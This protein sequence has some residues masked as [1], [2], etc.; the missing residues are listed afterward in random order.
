M[1]G[2]PELY[3]TPR[4]P[5]YIGGYNWRATCFGLP[6]MPGWNYMERLYRPR[7]EILSG[8]WTFPDA[9]PVQ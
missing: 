9:Q 7:A 3:R 6:I 8:N 2:Q 5:G 1:S 4:K